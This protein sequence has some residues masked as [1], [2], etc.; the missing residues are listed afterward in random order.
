[1]ERASVGVNGN[2]FL[3]NYSYIDADT[4][5]LPFRN[6]SGSFW[7]SNAGRNHTVFGYTYPEL[8][9]W[10]YKTDGEYQKNVTAYI[11]TT[12]GG[13]V[14]G[15]LA[16]PAPATAGTQNLLTSNRTF[17]DWTIETSAVASAAPHTFIVTFSFGSDTRVGTWMVLMPSD[18]TSDNVQN[19]PIARRKRDSTMS[20][21]HTLSGTV[22]LTTQLIYHIGADLE[23]L[24]PRDVVP[25]LTQHLTWEV[26]LVCLP[27]SLLP[28]HPSHQYHIFTTLWLVMQHWH[29]REQGDGTLLPSEQLSAF[30]FEIFS[31][32]ARIP[33][34]DNEMI[35]YEER[36]VSHPD[37]TV[38]KMGGAP[39]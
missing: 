19:D 1:M 36:G 24:D 7:T 9:R 4:P 2:V 30:T 29:W 34:D 22:G 5:L 33:E 17:T 23:S 6:A 14:R 27:L 28:P 26:K 35:E 16:T 37:V 3:E 25:F 18:H 10:K 20:E 13:S 8:Q 21:E 31:S 32:T 15:L 39:A 12:Y 38:G 11:A